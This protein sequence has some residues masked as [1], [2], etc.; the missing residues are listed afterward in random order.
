MENMGTLKTFDLA[1]SRD[2]AQRIY[3]QDVLR[4]QADEL[5]SWMTR[6][7]SFMSVAALMAWLQV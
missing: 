6:V 4:E 5:I 7:R 2:Q 1:F 3:V